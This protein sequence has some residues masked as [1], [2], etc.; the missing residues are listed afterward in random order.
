MATITESRPP[1]L[2]QQHS[3][4]ISPP[5]SP[6]CIVTWF[7]NGQQVTIR[8]SV[9]GL[10][11]KGFGASGQMTV[12]VVGNTSGTTVEART[13]CPEQPTTVA[14]PIVVGSGSFNTCEQE[15]CKTSRQ[16]Y[17]NSGF[18]AIESERALKLICGLYK[19]F[20][21]AVLIV[22]L[23][24]VV[25]LALSILCHLVLTFP[26]LC[27]AIDILLL[28]VFAG[29]TFAMARLLLLRTELQR[30]QR[31]CAIDSALLR[32]KYLQMQLDCPRDCWVPELKV[33]CDC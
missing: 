25:L 33:N 4:S 22:F 6:G 15:P 14:G 7:I 3:Y 13:E 20:L 31:L 29:L 11:V 12:E 10:E 17:I 16:N 30:R 32:I 19:L 9:G 24:F 8:D 2:G 26:T 27:V 21:T 1:V 5:P 23:Y 18:I 28:A